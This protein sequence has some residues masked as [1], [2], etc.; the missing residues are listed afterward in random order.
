MPEN[1]YGYNQELLE[2]DVKS[3]FEF[4]HDGEQEQQHVDDKVEVEDAADEDKTDISVGVGL[5]LSGFVSAFALVHTLV[6]AAAFAL[7]S[8]MFIPLAWL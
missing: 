3:D 1:G 7:S 6:L 4:E 8:I 5:S 2:F